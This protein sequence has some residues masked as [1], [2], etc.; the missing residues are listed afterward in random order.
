MATKTPNKDLYDKLKASNKG[1]MNNILVLETDATWHIYRKLSKEEQANDFA[2]ATGKITTAWHGFDVFEKDFTR[3]TLESLHQS[4][5]QFKAPSESKMSTMSLA[6]LIWNYRNYHATDH[7]KPAESQVP[8]QTPGQRF[9]SIGGRTYKLATPIPGVHKPYTSKAGLACL[10]IITDMCKA[11]SDGTVNE[12]MLKPEVMKRASEITP[13]TDS[14]WRFLQFYRPLL[15][16]AG[17]IE[18]QK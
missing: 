10:K 17:L 15:V 18:Y 8:G 4:I 13:K 14:A 1:N 7:S 12:A 6:L 2:T 5:F 11:S 3:K 16:D 9:S